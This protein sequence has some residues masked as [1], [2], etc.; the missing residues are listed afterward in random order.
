MKSQSI[1][2]N[3]NPYTSQESKATHRRNKNR[4]RSHSMESHNQI[5]GNQIRQKINMELTHV[6][7]SRQTKAETFAN[8]PQIC[9]KSELN[10]ER[11]RST[12]TK[13][14]S[15]QQFGGPQPQRDTQNHIQCT[16]LHKK[17]NY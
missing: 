9:L 2:K 15:F 8:I 11:T 12:F 1:R 10:K 17:H 4:K 6:A 16:I 3:P 5:P 13:H 7:I 14:S